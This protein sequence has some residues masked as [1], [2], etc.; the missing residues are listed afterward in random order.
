MFDRL[1]APLLTHHRHDAIVGERAG[2]A[3][4]P[5]VLGGP[6]FILAVVVRSV[7]NSLSSP[8]V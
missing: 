5:P 8:V 2:F 4:I 7:M 6:P 1:G 3:A